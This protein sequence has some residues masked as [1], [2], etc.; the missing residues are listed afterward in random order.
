MSLNLKN[1]DARWVF[2][3]FIIAVVIPIVNPLGLPIE[4]NE[5]TRIV[6]E[7][8]ESVPD[9][10]L[11]VLTPDFSYDNRG[12]LLPMLEV[13]FKHL[14]AKNVKIISVSFYS[15]QSP[16][17]MEEAMNAVGL[18]EHGKV[19]GVDFVNLGYIA[20]DEAS[21]AAIGS[22]VKALVRVDYYG[23]PI[24]DIPI[25]DM[26]NDAGDIDL[27]VSLAAGMNYPEL[28]LRQWQTTY[29]TKVTGG[30]VGL[31]YAPLLPYIASGQLEGY[32]PSLRGA[33]EYELVSGYAGAAIVGMDSQSLAHIVV[34]AA[35][36]VCN[37]AYW[38]GDKN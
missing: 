4:I 23:T 34:I 8:L 6:Y 33:A 24:G 17:L 25:M 1:I 19:Y 28:Y 26:F 7:A 11:V 13:M 22:D 31:I 18:E 12:E 5:N 3:L 38:V 2:V 16:L 15:A 32:L 20:G 21:V 10:G 36:V 37:I 14:L 27:A 9:G 29:G 30:S 35:I